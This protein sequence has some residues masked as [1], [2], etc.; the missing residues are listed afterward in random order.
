MNPRN[1]RHRTSYRQQT[2]STDLNCEHLE[3]RFLLSTVEILAAGQT[4]EETINLQIDGIEVQSWDNLGG[5]AL[6]GDFVT[7]TYSTPDT[8]TADQIRIQFANDLFDPANGVDRNVRIDAIVIDGQRFETEGPGVFSTGTWLP[9]DGV[10]PGFRESEYLHTNGYF[11][12]ADDPSDGSVVSIVARGDEGTEQMQLLVNGEA[13]ALFDVSQTDATY[14]WQA[15]RT[16][17]ADEIR[18]RF[19]NDQWDPTNGIDANL[20]VDRIEIDGTSYETESPS[21]LSTGTWLNGGVTPGFYETEIL[22]TVGYFEYSQPTVEPG[23]IGLT[24]DALSIDESTGT[25]NV[26]V[27]RDGNTDGTATVNYATAHGTTDNG[28]Y[29]SI[30]GILEFGPGI[31]GQQLELAIIDDAVIEDDETFTINLSNPTN[32]TLGAI[33]TQTVTIEDNDQITAGILLEDSFEG[34]AAWTTDPFGT[35]TATTGQWA[36]GAP[37]ETSSGGTIMQ[38]G[39]GSTGSRALVTGLSS[40]SSVGTN[41]IDNGVTS[42]LSPE[43]AIPAGAETQLS[44]E[45]VLAHLGNSSSDDFFRASIVADGVQTQLLDDQGSNQVRAAAWQAASFDISQFGGQAIQI[46]FEA[47]DAQGGSLV[48][49]AVDDVVVEVL[50]VLPGTF[51]I[52]NPGINV[53]ESAGSATFTITRTSGRLGA[54][55]VDYATTPGTA[56]TNDFTGASGTLNFADGQSEATVTIPIID[57]SLEEDLES[58]SFSLANPT[59][60]ALLGSDTIGTVTIADNDNT[61]GDYL[62]DLTP[63]AS[64]LGERLSID[65]NEIPGRT[66]M[67]FSTEV[68]NAGTG[69]LEIWGG[70]T[71]GNSQQVFQRIYQEDGGSRDTLAGEFVYHPGHGHIHFEGFATYDLVDSNGNVVASGGKTSFCLINIRQPFPGVSANADVVHGRGGNSCGSIQGISAGYSDVYSASLDD[72]WIDVTNVADGDYTLQIVTDP[73]NNIQEADESNNQTSITVRLQN[74]SVS[75]L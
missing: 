4:N 51:N 14:T 22:H 15:G 13:V 73:D 34:S 47:A 59:G 48:E 33:A 25:L 42:V 45:Y 66:L 6:A 40:G 30:S 10:T 11:E 70:S 67:R 55:S 39:S 27:F 5:D 63:I 23:T 69:P 72:Q 64:T 29:Q 26:I 1:K 3:Q 58:F 62:P 44:F 8:L 36:A 49:S 35:D 31:T 52:A 20:I 24:L 50:P 71:S 32:A 17:T 37:S 18:V 7:L 65:R 74:G 2:A 19:T 12:Y 43:I 54:V 75:A 46:L 38:L 9:A 21:T 60:G 41:D 61:I 16:V 56:G 68:A 28:D 57:D 53:D